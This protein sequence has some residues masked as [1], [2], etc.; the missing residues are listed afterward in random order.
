MFCYSHISVS[1]LHVSGRHQPSPSVSW[2]EKSQCSSGWAAPPGG[3]VAGHLSV[4]GSAHKDAHSS[5][6]RGNICECV[7]VRGFSLP[8]LTRGFA[9]EERTHTTQ[10][11][12]RPT[13]THTQ[14]VKGPVCIMR[15]QDEAAR[16]NPS[17]R[18]RAAISLTFNSKKKT[19]NS[20]KSTQTQQPKTV[21]PKLT[22]SVPS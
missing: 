7:H 20:H 19:T 16:T 2:R 13:D 11:T 1:C 21:G 14:M 22:P 5:A 15:S 10:H 4:L 18:L 9:E 12:N 17:S 6:H 3:T 8:R